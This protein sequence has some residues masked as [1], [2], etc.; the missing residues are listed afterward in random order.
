M[1]N[2]GKNFIKENSALLLAAGVIFITYNSVLKPLLESLGLTKSAGEVNVSAEN[3]NPNSA[4][5]PLFWQ[6]APSGSLILTQNT[7][8]QFIDTIYNSVG[9]IYDDFNAVL[10]VFKQLKS[11]SQVSYLVDAFNK[12]K[13]ADLLTWLLGGG[14]FSYP[15]DRYSA[16]QVNQLIQLVNN[17]PNY[18]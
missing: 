2:D 12:S 14:I 17:L 8:N 9:Y 18:K 11:K 6:K 1:A 3:Q 13:N 10:G 5:N 15:S 4:W 16:E 7:T